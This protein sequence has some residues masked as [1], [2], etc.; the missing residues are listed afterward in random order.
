M[1]VNTA[2]RVAGQAEPGQLLVTRAVRDSAEGGAAEW[3]PPG[4][5]KLK[6]LAEPVELFA[7]LRSAR[8]SAR[9]DPV[10]GMNVDAGHDSVVPSSRLQGV[11]FCSARCREQFDADPSRYHVERS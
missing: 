1:T 5:R 3:E 9:R 8:H 6:G 2:A 11:Y 7:A 10:C 4:E